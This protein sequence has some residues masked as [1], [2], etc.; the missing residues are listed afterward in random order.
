[1]MTKR[2]SMEKFKYSEDLLE[3]GVSKALG[4]LPLSTIEEYGGDSAISDLIYDAYDA[5][6]EAKIIDTGTTGSGALYVWNVKMLKAILDEYKNI[7][8]EAGVPTEVFDYVWHVE[9]HLID[10]KTHPHAYMV[11][12]LTFN[13]ARFR[14][15]SVK[16]AE[17]FVKRM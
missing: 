16:D 10:S 13:D 1:M 4:Y 9:H 2:Q 15:K 3:V 8:T 6:N 14:D 5:G 7:L 11:V 17:K 12:G